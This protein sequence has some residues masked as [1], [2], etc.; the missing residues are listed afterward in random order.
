MHNNF[1]FLRQLSKALEKILVGCV[2][3]ECFS[4][5]KD[6]LIIR[7]ETHN[8]PFF[9]KA[10]LEPSFSCLTFP[11]DFHRARK[12]SIDLFPNLIGH[13]VA[14][15][16]Q[17]QNERSF[18]LEMDS[19]TTLLFKMHGNRSNIILFK[20]HSI[21]EVFRNNIDADST[22]DISTLD[23]SIDWRYENLVANEA[24]L[25]S[26]YFTFGKLIWKVLT[27]QHVET[28]STKEKWTMIQQ[29]IHEIENPTYYITEVEGSLYLSLLR[30][31]AI[32]KEFNDPI[33]AV[34]DFYYTYTHT[35]AFTKEK[36]AALSILR[37]TIHAGENY[38]EKTLHKLEEVEHNNNYKMWADLIMANLHQLKTGEEKT[39]LQNFYTNQPTTIKL[40]K[41]LS[42]QKNAEV[43]YRKAKN[44]HLEIARLQQ[45]LAI[46]TKEIEKLRSQLLQLESTDTLKSLRIVINSFGL[47]NERK[48]EAEPLPFHEFVH[49]GFKIW[50]GKNAKSND[51]LTL[52]YSYKDDLWLHAK[53][54]A[55]SHVL[56]KYQSG[57][58]F[59]KDVIARAAQLAAYNSKRKTETLCPVSVTSKKFVRKRKG[60]P[61]GAVVVEREEV[62][63]VEPKL[64]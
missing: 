49:N 17:F 23:R 1:Y 8:Q 21:D 12:N 45:A 31:G 38:Y 37:N 36:S 26:C 4:Q 52:R 24:T 61:A 11:P 9:I 22:I 57:K 15:I 64:E 29:V 40:K 58:T 41:E 33:H 10:S 44:Q 27:D 47:L 30:Y 43:Y 5:N 46:K 34:N 53:D 50:V 28:K 51:A 48:Q 39:T 56:I 7:L 63:L 20:N 25:Q 6:E 2:V 13:R 59:P 42:P 19:N 62:I 18:A 60:D 16:R 35:L 3:S 14:S 55:G 54:V 32:K